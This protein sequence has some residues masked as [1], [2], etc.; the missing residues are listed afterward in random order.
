MQVTF[1]NLLISLLHLT[2]ALAQDGIPVKRGRCGGLFFLI[3][4]RGRLAVE[5]INLIL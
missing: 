1:C 5:V 3:D 4:K 2:E